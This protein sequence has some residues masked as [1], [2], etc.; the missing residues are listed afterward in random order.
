[1]KRRL[2]SF[3]VVFALCFAT[4]V[5]VDARSQ[6][7]DAPASGRSSD[8]P[9]L[10]IAPDGDLATGS[11]EE[12]TNDVALA[13]T[14]TSS[15][16][17]SNELTVVECPPTNASGLAGLLGG[18]FSGTLFSNPDE[19]IDADEFPLASSSSKVDELDALVCSRWAR[20]PVGSWARTRTTT[21]TYEEG[22]PIQSVTETRATLKRVD[23]QACRYEL[24]FDSTIKLGSVDFTRKSETVEYDFWD[25]PID[26]VVK[27]ETLAPVNLKIGIRTI[28]CQTRRV[29]RETSK[30]T[31]TTT[32]W[33]STVFAPYILQRQTTRDAKS[34]PTTPASNEL[35]VAQK[36]AGRI[37]L[38]VAPT[39]FVARSSY[40]SATRNV[41]STVVYSPTTPGGVQ[42]ET[43][44]ETHSKDDPVVYQSN[45]ALLDYY[46][47]Q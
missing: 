31:E 32:L 13:T 42:R 29:T 3:L 37:S 21:V 20:F 36:I 43:S 28:P 38:G 2:F 26:G 34:D 12:S 33:Y 5:L 24:Q 7:S 23:F 46:I 47:A 19:P 15:D 17:S 9:A 4:R 1:M 35:F 22:R 44:L 25:V 45:T 27:V 8:L 16:A 41:S 18:L 39:N 40:A 11:N 10:A 14:G 30:G 6:E